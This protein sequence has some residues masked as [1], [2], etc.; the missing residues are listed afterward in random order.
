MKPKRIVKK[1]QRRID[2]YELTTKSGRGKWSSG[3]RKPGSLNQHKG[4]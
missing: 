4:G 1:L 2:S 3:Y